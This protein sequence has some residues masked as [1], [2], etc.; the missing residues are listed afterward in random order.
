MYRKH[1]DH[2]NLACENCRN[3]F[4]ARK[5]LRV[6]ITRIH[7]NDKDKEG[8]KV[9]TSMVRNCTDDDMK[10]TTK[11]NDDGEANRDIVNEIQSQISICEDSSKYY[12]IS[13]QSQFKHTCNGC[14]VSSNDHSKLNPHLIKVHN[15]IINLIE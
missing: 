10:V 6:H 13:R 9:L 2:G 14:D 7:K 1:N 5:D 3:L 11:D 4:N 12:Q 8:N 15:K